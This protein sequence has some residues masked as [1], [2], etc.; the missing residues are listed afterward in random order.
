VTVPLRLYCLPWAGGGASAFRSWPAAFG[1]GTEVRPIQL[2]GREERVRD[3]PHHR[4][5]ALIAELGPRLAAEAR[6]PFALF[7]HSMGALA[8]YELV[9]HLEAQG[10]PRPAALFLSGHGAPGAPRPLPTGGVADDT[11]VEHILALGG[12]DPDVFRDPELRQIALRALRADVEL[13]RTYRPTRPDPVNVPL[14]VYGGVD[15]H[16]SHASLAGWADHTTGPVR[17]RWFP[18]GHFFVIH[19]RVD[20]VADIQR[21]LTPEEEPA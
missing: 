21:S 2:P 7:G 19:A 17:L 6:P 9:S 1:A 3:E 8:A 13:C 10:G 4:M 12:T 16:W 20:L 5:A 18:G 11:L 14:V 15:D